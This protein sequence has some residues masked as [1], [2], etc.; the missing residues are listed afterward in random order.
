MLKQRKAQCV[1]N[2][3]SSHGCRFARA[4]GLE[5]H[6][7]RSR[8]MLLMRARW[9]GLQDSQSHKHKSCHGASRLYREALRLSTR[10]QQSITAISTEFSKLK[11]YLSS[12]KSLIDSRC[13]ETIPFILYVL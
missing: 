10:A 9:S 11:G 1:L 8:P 3:R 12:S 13:P 7:S 4:V 2:L 6:A 5:D